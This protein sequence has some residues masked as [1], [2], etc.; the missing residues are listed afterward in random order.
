[1]KIKKL[2]LNNFRNVEHLSLTPCDNINIIFGDNAQGKTNVMEAISMFSGNRRFRGGR[3]SELIR[4]GEQAMTAS[5]RYERE[6]QSYDLSIGTDKTHSVIRKN[7]RVVGTAELLNDGFFCS[8]FSPNHLMMIKGGPNERR[9]YLDGIICQMKP[10]YYNAVMSYAKAMK[11]RNALLK[12]IRLS[13]QLLDTLDYWDDIL[14]RYG[15]YIT[16]TR[17]NFLSLLSPLSREIYSGIADGRE[18]IEFKYISTVFDNPELLDGKEADEIYKKRLTAARS[19]DL[20]KCTTSVGIHRDDIGIM[21]DGQSARV[22]ASQGQHRS[23]VLSLMLGFCEMYKE[24]KNETPVILLDD[25]MSEL[26]DKRCDYLLNKLTGCQV[27]ITCCNPS[28][29]DS[30][31]AGRLFNI[32]RGSLRLSRT[33][34]EEPEGETDGGFNTED[35]GEMLKNEGETDMLD[36][37]YRDDEQNDDYPDLD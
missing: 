7:G 4:F 13:S 29:F 11:Q 10:Q 16:K 31:K 6:G 17:M 1:M 21:I 35:V 28:L 27:F 9:A 24:L 37:L 14:I 25:V 5:L 22:Y 33:V 32:C 20:S 2:E 23:A 19:E 30:L 3:D 12:D 18:E 26:D 34:S 15:V 36:A 8:D